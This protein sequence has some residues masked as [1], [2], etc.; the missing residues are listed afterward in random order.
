LSTSSF[1]EA[2]LSN[3]NQ[4]CDSKIKSMNSS[5]TVLESGVTPITDPILMIDS[6]KKKKKKK[7]KKT[8]SFLMV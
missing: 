8:L 1:V 7:K 5:A 4:S 3:I 6:E 2:T